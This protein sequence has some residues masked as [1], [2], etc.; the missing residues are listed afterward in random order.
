[1][2]EL[3]IAYTG[4]IAVL[5]TGLLFLYRSL[6]KRIRAVQSDLNERIEFRKFNSLVFASIGLVI[7]MGWYGI[8]KIE[9]N[10]LNDFKSVAEILA[11][12][13][14]DIVTRFDLSIIN[15]ETGQFDA[16]LNMLNSRLIHWL[17]LRPDLLSM[18][19]VKW[20]P[21]ADSMY[22]IGGA[23]HSESLNGV[24]DKDIH[25]M[26]PLGRLYSKIDPEP[27]LLRAFSGLFATE[28]EPV[29]NSRK[30]ALSSFAPIIDK[31]GKV[32]AVLG[33]D[34]DG[35]LIS[36]RI[37]EERAKGFLLLL[38]PYALILTGYWIRINS[39]LEHLIVTRKKEEL[40]KSEQRYHI[41]SDS[42]MEG[43]VIHRGGAILEV[44]RA[45]A[46]M[47][48]Y[49]PQE[50]ISSSALS[51][52]SPECREKIRAILDWKENLHT[53]TVAFRK[54]GTKFDVELFGK[55]CVYNGQPA[56][57][58][59]I[60]DITERKRHEAVI[61]HMASHDELTGLP[62]KNHF[63]Q[64]MRESLELA[65]IDGWKSVLLFMDLDKFKYINDSFGHTAGDQVLKDVAQRLR[66]ICSD[67]AFLGR[68]GGD[69]FT[70]FLPIANYRI[71]AI[72]MAERVLEAMAEPMAIGNNRIKMGTS[73]GIS[74]FPEHGQDAETLIMNA[75]TAMYH[76]KRK[77]QN[78]ITMFTP[79]MQT[80]ILNRL[81]MGNDLRIALQN[82]EFEVYYQPQIHMGT[83]VIIGLE[84]LTRWKHPVK[85]YISPAQFI[86]VAEETRLMKPL[87]DWVLR[88][89]CS[90]VKELH[91]Q[92]FP[93][94]RLAVNLSPVQFEQEEL[95]G[96]IRTVLTETGFPA[97]LLE[98]EITESMT[99]D[100]D[101]VLPILSELKELG[102]QIS[103]D[104]FGT[105]YSSLSYLKSIP[106]DRLKIDRSFIMGI[107]TKQEPVTAIILS[108]ARNLNLDVIAE[109]VET[110]EQVEFLLREGCSEAQGYYYF[111]PMPMKGIID[112]F[113]ERSGSLQSL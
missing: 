101:Y 30:F 91:Q 109:G 59:A 12:T 39:Y 98:L 8:Q 79:D 18:Y 66:V 47:L 81:T 103:I 76:G 106:I 51:L 49:Q 86:P 27:E 40:E 92:G 54:D 108:L 99:M 97:E 105:G 37:L 84:A 56:R 73:I 32:Q 29:A 28:P 52:I 10:E 14:A 38:L 26:I 2:L 74:L 61:Y 64:L 7:T 24:E 78:T 94:M 4:Y 107:Q 70:I 19:V 15:M 69:E 93:K 111:R 63:T 11:P 50:L 72:R 83:E 55:N 80:D 95:A 57:A 77:N 43:L 23:T 3:W 35:S 53:E 34:M 60:R 110:K 36:N 48:G 75:D 58:V 112:M 31:Y 6:H 85:G 100:V 42:S 102:V 16:D 9:R 21:F 13:Y 62:N 22:Y 67:G 71:D 65:A 46:V 88:K 68:W 33:I 25:K 41:L 1:M 45:L 89:A 17:E 5:L 96:Y 104:D 20:D 113:N 87:G 82:G 90:E 44:N